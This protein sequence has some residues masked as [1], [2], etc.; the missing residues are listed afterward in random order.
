MSLNS[1]KKSWHL[2]KCVNAGPNEDSDGSA[3]VYTIEKLS[4]RPIR[5]ELQLN[6]KPL[7]MEVD[8]GAAVSLIS[9]KRLK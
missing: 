5:V 3:N 6:G 4:T 9:Y 7:A 8:I 2:C 1:S